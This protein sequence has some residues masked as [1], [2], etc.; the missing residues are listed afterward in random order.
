MP[1]GLACLLV[2]GFNT[3]ASLSFFEIATSCRLEDRENPLNAGVLDTLGEVL[4]YI[5][6]PAFFFRRMGSGPAFFFAVLD[7]SFGFKKNLS[8][9]V[10]KLNTRH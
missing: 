8:G 10:F 9:D 6:G 4:S 2:E 5:A 7:H 3:L 1:E